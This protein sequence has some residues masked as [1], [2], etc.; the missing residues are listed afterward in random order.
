MIPAFD[1]ESGYLPP[2]VHR[3]TLVEIEK[4][5]STTPSRKRLFAGFMR[6]AREL[7]AAGCATVYLDGSFITN[8]LDPGDY[9]AVWEYQ[10]MD[11]R[12]DGVLRDGTTAQI[13]RKY[14]GDIFCRMPEILGKDHVE[15]FQSDRTGVPKG[16]IR[17]DLRKAL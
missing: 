2:G 14:L 9:D 8:K 15:F 1:E 11:N 10:G 3:A 12:I 7:Q 16:I 17:V 13:K 6:L 4:R 5:Y